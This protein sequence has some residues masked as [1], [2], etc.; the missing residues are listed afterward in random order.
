MLRLVSGNVGDGSKDVGTVSGRSLDTVSD[1][2][3][4]IVLVRDKTSPVV[5]SPLASF[6]VDIK[7]L[8]IVVKVDTT[9]TQVPTEEGSVRGEDG[10]DINVPLSAESNGKTGLPFVKVGDDGGVGL[11]AGE[12]RGG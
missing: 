8:K 9:S 7:I 4:L 6:V 1:Y 5:D 2:Q 10:G 12:L 11:P 3:L